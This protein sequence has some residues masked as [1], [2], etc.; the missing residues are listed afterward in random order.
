MNTT[1]LIRHS[2]ST[3]FDRQL[4]N[5]EHN[6]GVYHHTKIANFLR[7]PI[8]YNFDTA[9]ELLLSI[10]KVIEETALLTQKELLLPP[11]NMALFQCEM[12]RDNLALMPN[13]AISIGEALVHLRCMNKSKIVLMIS[14]TLASLSLW[15]NQVGNQNKYVQHGIPSSPAL[16]K[17]TK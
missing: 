10:V 5:I 3:F 8:V 11:L 17:A 12:I 16:A 14:E 2:H 6:H 13:P 4:N 15:F 7:N 1:L 9:A